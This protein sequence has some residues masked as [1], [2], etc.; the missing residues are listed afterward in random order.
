ATP[1]PPGPWRY[2]RAP[3]SVRSFRRAARQ[4]R[5]SRSVSILIRRRTRVLTA[6]RRMSVRALK[7]SGSHNMRSFKILPHQRSSHGFIVVAVSWILAALATL[8]ITYGVYVKATAFALAGYDVRLQ[9]QE[10]AMAG[11]EL[12]VYKLTESPQAQPAQ[13]KFGFRLGNADVAVDFRSESGR[14]DL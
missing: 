2:R 6:E 10:L 11:V 8:A 1:R 13:G 9:A 4:R 3:S 12:A 7:N 5:Q 14:I